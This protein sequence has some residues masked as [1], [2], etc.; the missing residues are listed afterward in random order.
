MGQVNKDM[1]DEYA[2]EITET[3]KRK[4]YVRVK[5][6]PDSEKKALEKIERRYHGEEIVLDWHDRADTKFKV[7]PMK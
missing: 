1:Y 2:V 4:V 5:K 6:S 3:L 7:V